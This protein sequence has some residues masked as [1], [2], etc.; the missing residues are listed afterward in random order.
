MTIADLNPRL[1]RGNMFSI[2]SFFVLVWTKVRYR[3]H[4]YILGKRLRRTRVSTD[5]WD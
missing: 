4:V 3:Y 1:R 2:K 5:I